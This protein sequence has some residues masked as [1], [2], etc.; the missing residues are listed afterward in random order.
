M[1]LVNNNYHLN[2][3]E[4]QNQHSTERD[5]EQCEMKAFCSLTLAGMGAVMVFSLT[6]C[7][8]CTMA[9]AEVA[10]AASESA[11]TNSPEFLF[12]SG[13]GS[14]G[15]C[16]DEGCSCDGGGS[17]GGA[18]LTVRATLSWAEMERK[19]VAPKTESSKV[20]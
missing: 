17:C 8:R 4:F 19:I 2:I 12:G 11:A 13:G 1:K 3:T 5:L 18:E 20:Q 7:C 10:D 9:N 15:G 16:D 14:S 6:L